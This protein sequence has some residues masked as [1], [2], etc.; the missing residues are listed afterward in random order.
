MLLARV[1]YFGY[2]VF[3]NLVILT[4]LKLIDREVRKFSKPAMMCW[5]MANTCNIILATIRI[6]NYS[7]KIK[8]LKK[9]IKKDPSK[10]QV[11]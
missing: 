9:M 6:K 3:D 1:S 2:W 7:K 11:Y 10:K 8:H 4:T 5:W